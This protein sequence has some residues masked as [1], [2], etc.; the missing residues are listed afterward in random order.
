MNKNLDRGSWVRVAKRLSGRLTQDTRLALR[1]RD[2]WT[3][4]TIGMVTGLRNRKC[5]ALT[6]RRRRLVAPPASWMEFAR[7][8]MHEGVG[9]ALRWQ[10]S[11]WARWAKA[12]S[13][14]RN[15]YR[16]RGPSTWSEQCDQSMW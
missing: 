15:R 10:D 16:A 8:A 1:K 5:Q 13:V 12:R 2:A 3:N 4:A 6:S 14:L 9:A 7:R 11:T